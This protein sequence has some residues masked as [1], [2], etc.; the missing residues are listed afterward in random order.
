MVR[1]EAGRG[2][3]TAGGSRERKVGTEPK[4]GRGSGVDEV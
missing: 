4:G 2:R 1:K 3:G